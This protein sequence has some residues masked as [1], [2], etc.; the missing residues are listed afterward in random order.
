M[1]AYIV[2]NPHT[3]DPNK[4]IKALQQQTEEVSYNLDENAKPD[5]GAFDI[6]RNTLNRKPK[7]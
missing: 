4:M 6:L 7:P 5:P 1:Q 3:K 2:S